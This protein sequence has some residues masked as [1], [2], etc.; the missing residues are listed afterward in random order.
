MA[1]NLPAR[2]Q[3]EIRLG[4]DQDV[5]EWLATDLTLD[6][7]ILVRMLGPEVGE[8]RRRRFL[9][10]V[11]SLASVTHPHLLEV[12]AAGTDGEHTWMVAEWT[13]GV[14][15]ADR[16][17]AGTPMP[18]EEFLP[19]AAG[20][21]DALA[22][23][24]SLDVAHG[25]IGPHAVSFAAAHPAKLM[26]FSH[27]GPEGNRTAD[28][29]D[30][31]RTLETA[32][33]GSSS[34]GLAPSQLTDAIHRSVDEALGEAK[35]GRLSAPELAARLKAAPTVP[36][37][38]RGQRWSWRWVIPALV[39][40]LGA[41]VVTLIG[42]FGGSEEVP[43]FALPE[44]PTTTVA[45]TT[46][47][48]T[49]L[50]EVRV[51]V[52]D[53]LDPSEDGERDGEL[54]NLTDGDPDTAWRTE[55]YF[56]PISLIKPGVGVTFVLDRAPT[57]V[58]FDASPG[59]GFELRWA[60][61]L[62]NILEDWETLAAGSVVGEPGVAS[63]TALDLPRRD[64]GFWLLWLTELAFQGQSDDDPPRDFFYTFVYE[65]RFSP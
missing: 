16:M 61:T 50:P 64:G 12:Y 4:R 52:V 62:P 2:Y 10:E 29:A 31:A 41:L 26:A 53:V 22:E 47:T 24:H 36:G 9:A 21:A 43:P 59:T 11:R 58:E 6:R 1:A 42:P 5:E 25:D 45:P 32:L 65:V 7:P 30:L 13:G 18:V 14:T 27:P 57:M 49:T 34:D 39:L 3:L 33:S 37:S 38:R 23:L 15:V 48:T 54:P 51:I 40:A 20:L 35:A 55:R 60:P 46:T 44:P 56:A 28:V 63:T 17:E 8:Q 19:N